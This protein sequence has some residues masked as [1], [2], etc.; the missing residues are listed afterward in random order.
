M[1]R[2]LRF[3]RGRFVRPTEVLVSALTPH[4]E[5][6]E[7]ERRSGEDD[8]GRP[9]VEAKPQD[10]V[11]LVGAQHLDEPATDRV[12]HPVE[13]EDLAPGE[14]E[15]AVDQ[16]QCEGY[17]KAPQRLVEEGRLEG[18]IVLVDGGSVRR[19][20]LQAPRHS[21]RSP[22]Q[23]LVE[24]VPPAADRLGQNYSGGSRVGVVQE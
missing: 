24:V 7:G 5:A 15:P 1:L 9:D 17:E 18:R 12:A 23:L 3:V 21:G 20:D 13:R 11:G 8:Q 14:T 6:P 19:R 22:E 4:A 2:W 10:V 16:N